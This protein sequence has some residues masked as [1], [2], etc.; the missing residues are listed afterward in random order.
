MH[1]KTGVQKLCIAGR[2]QHMIGCRENWDTKCISV[3]KLETELDYILINR[4][5]AI[6]FYLLLIWSCFT[7]R[8]FCI[9]YL[10]DGLLLFTKKLGSS[11]FGMDSSSSSNPAPPIQHGITSS[12]QRNLTDLEELEH[13]NVEDQD[14]PAP[15]DYYW[16]LQISRKLVQANCPNFQFK[17]LLAWRR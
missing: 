9:R 15:P 1:H 5:A 2:Q 10:Y 16:L 17:D 14:S 8:L 11:N 7:H 12:F 3:Q 4:P 13:S 6:F